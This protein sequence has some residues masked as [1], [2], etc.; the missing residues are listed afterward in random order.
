MEFRFNEAVGEKPKGLFLSSKRLTYVIIKHMLK[1]LLYALN[2]RE[3]F[4][5]KK[6]FYNKENN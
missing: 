4:Y 6:N 2:V 3:S 1:F 5:N